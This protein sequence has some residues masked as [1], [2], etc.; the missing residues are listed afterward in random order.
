MNSTHVTGTGIHGASQRKVHGVSG[1]SV[2]VLDLPV[3]SK[4]LHCGGVLGM[5]KTHHVNWRVVL[6]L[7][8]VVVLLVV[9]VTLHLSHLHVVHQQGVILKITAA[10]LFASSLLV[11]QL[12]LV[13]YRK[14]NDECK[15]HE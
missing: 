6:Q 3:A 15:Y 8:L 7:G 2:V 11:R 4:G 12:V 1:K 9:L 5:F 14:Y 13:L 10:H